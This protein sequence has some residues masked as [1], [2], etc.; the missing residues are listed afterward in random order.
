MSIQA[1]V[2]VIGFN[3]PDFLKKSL[4]NIPVD[5]RKVYISID[6]ARNSIEAKVVA[7]CISLAKSYANGSGNI[8]EVQNSTT[9]L[10]CKEGVRWAIDWIF[11]HEHQAIIIEDDI[12]TTPTFFDYCDKGLIEFE[13]DDKIWQLNGFTPLLPPYTVRKFYVS[14]YAHIWGWATWKSRWVKYDRHLENFPKLSIENLPPFTRTP[15]SKKFVEYF[16]TM[17]NDCK[18][19]FDTW[20]AQW[21]YSMW[22]NDARAIAPGSRLTGNFGFD[23]R[24]SHTTRAG[25][26][27]R[28]L[29]P[30][31]NVKTHPIDFVD[32]TEIEKLDEL[33]E[34]IE[35]GINS[36]NTKMKFALRI[37]LEIKIRYLLESASILIQGWKSFRKTN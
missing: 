15:P 6:G 26:V 36:K 20:D 19:G 21:V 3:R 17:L 18:N 7:K 10:G 22:L 2:L 23:H 33:H 25:S 35:F 12:F 11:Q 9:N 30:K 37:N 14:N 27:G 28:N 5:G 32:S 29:P 31:L 8:V 1:P 13:Q 16:N 34:I 24:A 4:S